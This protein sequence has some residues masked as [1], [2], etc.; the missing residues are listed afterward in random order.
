MW[1]GGDVEEIKIRKEGKRKE[2]VWV[3]SFCDIGTA[4]ARTDYVSNLMQY[5]DIDASGTCL[6]NQFD[7]QFC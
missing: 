6:H 4:R 1:N 3:S 2:V 5:L 7:V